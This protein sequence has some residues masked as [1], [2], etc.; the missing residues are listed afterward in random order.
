[1]H[2][3]FGTYI[4]HKHTY[5]LPKSTIR[6]VVMVQNLEVMSK[7]FMYIKY[8]LMLFQRNKN[9]KVFQKV[10]IQSPENICKAIYFWIHL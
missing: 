9:M 3:K 1:M 7:N 4:G 6:N 2:V 5:T 8:I 10:R